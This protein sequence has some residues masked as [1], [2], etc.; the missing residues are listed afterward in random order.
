[1]ASNYVVGSK[2]V[3]NRSFDTL[4]EALNGPADPGSAVYKKLGYKRSRVVNKTLPFEAGKTY[5]NANGEPV[6][7]ICADRRGSYGAKWPLLGLL[8]RDSEEILEAYD[9]HGYSSNCYSL[10]PETISGV[11]YYLEPISE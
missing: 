5:Y 1:M 3:P 7:I 2:N 10:I 6:R 8:F 11:E 9:L 4:Q